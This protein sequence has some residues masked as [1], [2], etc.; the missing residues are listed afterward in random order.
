M[1]VEGTEEGVTEWISNVQALRY[2]DYQC[3]RKPSLLDDA[4]QGTAIKADNEG[5]EEIES[6][7]DFADKMSNFGLLSW[8]RT[9]MGYEASDHKI[10]GTG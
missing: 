7:A 9:A 1:Y 4:V 5:F 8:W 3:V 2:K 6:V 10:G